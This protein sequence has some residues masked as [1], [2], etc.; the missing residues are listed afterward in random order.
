MQQ[1][2]NTHETSHDAEMAVSGQTIAPLPGNAVAGA[3]VGCWISRNGLSHV[4]TGLP[5][6]SRADASGRQRK[7]PGGCKKMIRCCTIGTPLPHLW[8]NRRR[9]RGLLNSGHEEQ[10]VGGLEHIGYCGF[11]PCDQSHTPRPKLRGG[12]REKN[13]MGTMKCSFLNPLID[14]CGFGEVVEGVRGFEN[15]RRVLQSG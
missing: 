8:I 9:G 5:G 15:F 2:E 14:D 10:H 1:I 6:R 12:E 7:T 3:A 4:H 11:S 13:D